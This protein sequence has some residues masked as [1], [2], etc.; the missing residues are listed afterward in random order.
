[1]FSVHTTLEEFNN[2]TITGYFVFGGWR[3]L[4]QRNHV[5]MMMMMMMMMPSLSKRSVFKRIPVHI[6]TQSRHFQI[7]RVQ[8]VFSKS[9]G[10]VTHWCVNWQH[11]RLRSFALLWLVWTVGLN[12]QIKLLFQSPP[13]SYER[14]ISLFLITDIT[15]LNCYWWSVILFLRRMV[16]RWLLS[17]LSTQVPGKLK[18]KKCLSWLTK[19]I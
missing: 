15:L 8:R 1:M 16:M 5:M 14:S 17:L 10:V 2:A 6:K 9:S 3:K 18:V 7:P 12:V 11:F 19:M 13:A 4:G